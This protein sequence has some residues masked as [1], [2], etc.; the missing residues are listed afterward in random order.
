MKLCLM[1]RVR[2]TLRLFEMFSV[3]MSGSFFL[4]LLVLFTTSSYSMLRTDSTMI[5]MFLLNYFYLIRRC[6]AIHTQQRKSF[7]F[8]DRGLALSMAHES[9][10]VLSLWLKMGW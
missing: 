4:L 6:F 2:I 1:A 3:C 7:R 9:T 5:Y 10:P 8:W